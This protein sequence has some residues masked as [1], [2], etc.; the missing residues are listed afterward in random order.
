MTNSTV[1]DT[2]DNQH[3]LLFDSRIFSTEVGMRPAEPC[4]ISVVATHQ[5]LTNLFEYLSVVILSDPRFRDFT[6]AII[7][8]QDLKWLEKCNQMNISALTDIVSA[9]SAGYALDKAT[10]TERDLRA[11]GDLWADHV[12]ENAKAYIM[13]I[14]YILGTVISGY[15]LFHG[16]AYFALGMDLSASGWKYLSTYKRSL[17]GARSSF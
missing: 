3:H 14:V 9:N 6:N 7:T 2:A 11:A 10:R 13:S 17:F 1:D 15:P 8:E 12:L 4:S 16:I 5:L